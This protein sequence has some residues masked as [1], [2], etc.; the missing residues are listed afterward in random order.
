MNP[1][2]PFRNR[3]RSRRGNLDDNIV[4]MPPLRSVVDEARPQH[5]SPF[6]VAWL[7]D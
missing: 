3:L 4:D 2:G 5:N 7:G 1:F 6:L